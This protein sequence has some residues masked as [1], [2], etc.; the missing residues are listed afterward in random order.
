MTSRF[1]EMAHRAHVTGHLLARENASRSLAL[2][3]RAG[4]AMRQRVTVRRIVH[5]EVVLLIAP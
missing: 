3:D 2:A 5:L 1:I 4:S